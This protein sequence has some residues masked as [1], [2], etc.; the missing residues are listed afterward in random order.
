MSWIFAIGLA[1]AC[2]AAVVFAFRTPRTLWT[3]V[4][5]A[6]A[7]GLAGFAFQ[8]SPGLP[9]APATPPAGGPDGAGWAMV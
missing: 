9:S 6:L 2:F 4:L 7:L 8:A 1:L 5:A 3:S